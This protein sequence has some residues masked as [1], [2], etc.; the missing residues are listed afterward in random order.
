MRCQ[1]LPC[2]H[3][4][5]AVGGN[6][7]MGTHNNHVW[8]CFGGKA[9]RQGSRERGRP[10]G[11]AA[12][13]G[14]GQEAGWQTKWVVLQ[15]CLIGWGTRHLVRSVQACSKEPR[16]AG[17]Q[18]RTRA[19]E[20]RGRH[21][22]GRVCRPRHAAAG[23]AGPRAAQVCGAARRAV[24]AAV[25]GI[26]ALEGGVPR[27]AAAAG[28]QW[29]QCRKW[30]SQRWG[31]SD[32]AAAS[33]CAAS[34]ARACRT[35]DGSTAAGRYCRHGAGAAPAPACRCSGPQRCAKNCGGC[36]RPCGLTCT[37]CLCSSRRLAAPWGMTPPTGPCRGAG[38]SR[39]SKSQLAQLALSCGRP[40]AGP[41]GTAAGRQGTRGRLRL[42]TRVQR[43]RLLY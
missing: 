27:H 32:A 19:L 24:G 20:C 36:A 6:A 25:V 30:A 4:L 8:R 34:P 7:H 40:A 10:G 17:R 43:G 2:W 12:D 37:A 23:H 21:P 14:G 33:L 39:R 35:C 42:E 13:R 28:R 38:H 5:L 22:K 15:S 41:A 31:G 11:R 1:A 9:R 26:A 3:A 29:R 16:R 18:P